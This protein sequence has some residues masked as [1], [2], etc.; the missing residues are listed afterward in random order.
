MQVLLYGYA[1]DKAPMDE[2]GFL[3]YAAS[4]ADTEKA[5]YKVLSASKPV[6]PSKP[7]PTCH[8]VLSLGS[9]YPC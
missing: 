9:C 6:S 3:Q 8:L 1:G 5:V 4:F 2:E 7:Q